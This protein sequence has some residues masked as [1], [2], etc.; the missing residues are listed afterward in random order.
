M[1][2]EEK[3]QLV[4]KLYK[5]GKTMREISKEAHMSFSDIGPITKKLNEELE[6]KRK[7]I[8][9]ES[10]ALKLFRKGRNPVDVAISLN[11]PP[12]KAAGIYKK[13][14]ELRGLYK[15]LHLYEKVKPDISLL[16]KV[17]DVVKKYNLT[18]KD[19]IN[20]VDYA[21]E[22]L[23]LKDE[24][25]K[26]EWQL[27]SIL[28]QKDEANTSL[29][30]IKKKHA[31]LVEQIDKYND[32]SVGKSS[33]IENLDSK[34]RKLESYIS[35]LKTSDEYYTKFEQFAKE[36]L[37]SIINDR[38]WLL[39]AAVGAVIESIRKDPD[40]QMIINNIVES[41]ESY[42]A[43]LLDLSEELFEKIL[44]QLIDVTL[45]LKATQDIN[46]VNTSSSV[47]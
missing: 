26:L 42:Q 45:Q 11:L 16:V 24:I 7:K 40:K 39:G 32:I 37:D 29:L 22:H 41:E 20:I 19:I 28:N 23:Y 25:E 6:P 33:Y 1:N 2:R 15:L 5:E 47:Q 44:K 17:H 14:W 46:G 36:K 38:R 21:D 4:C 35:K 31:E 13:F 34:I 3:R 9:E 27:D 30:S 8:S 43:N 10:Q 12:S 18:K